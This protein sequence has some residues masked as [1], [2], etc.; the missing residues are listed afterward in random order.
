MVDV[1]T[2]VQHFSSTTWVPSPED[3]IPESR[4][5]EQAFC[6]MCKVQCL[7][8]VTSQGVLEKQLW[9]CYFAGRG[10]QFRM[11]RGVRQG[12]PASG[13]LFCNGVRPNF[14]MIPA[15]CYS[16][17]SSQPGL[18]ATSSMCICRRPRCGCSVISEFEDCI[19]TGS[20]RGQHC[21]PQFE[22]SGSAAGYNTVM[23]HG[24]PC[25]LGFLKIVRN[26][27]KCKLSSTLHIFQLW[28]A[29]I[30]AFIV[31]HAPRKKFIQRVMKINASTK[32]LA[33]RL[34]D[35]KTNAISVLS[36]IGSVYGPDQATLKAE[37]HA[38]QC[39]TAGA[40]NAIPSNLL[41]VG[42]ACGLGTDLVGHSLH[43]P[44]GPLASCCMFDHAQAR[45]L[46]KILLARGHNCA[47]LFALS[48]P[49]EK[50]FLLS[51][52]AH[53]TVTAFDTVRQLD[54]VGKLNE[55]PKK[56]ETE[57]RRWTTPWLF[58]LAGF[59]WANLC[60]RFQNF[61]TDQPLSCRR[62]PTPHGTRV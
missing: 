35:L 40:Y 9:S 27:E 50:E 24:N 14:Q 16:A 36:F 48:H 19:V 10:W 59:C 53:S 5:P 57:N 21:W 28:L 33:E 37:N 1:S 60:T 26:F 12:C 38:L 20:I 6:Q 41:R 43:Q 44:G 55:A 61:R 3:W 54:R 56:Q 39:T 31:G 11:A 4:E 58:V 30:V 52:V 34:C 45:R 13:F 22:L 46:G 18:L 51:S 42:S 15:G 47:P 8:V 25:A 29:L 62:Y 7:P 49:W 23:K 32:S 17:E 2:Y